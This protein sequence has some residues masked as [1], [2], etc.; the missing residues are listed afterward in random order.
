M[1]VCGIQ[2]CNYP[3]KLTEIKFKSRQ[4]CNFF[5]LRTTPTIRKF[6]KIVRQISLK[7]GTHVQII[8]ELPV[9]GFFVII[10]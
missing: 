5:F 3:K 8:V 10:V 1:I 2:L 7:I 4:R 9:N 6:R